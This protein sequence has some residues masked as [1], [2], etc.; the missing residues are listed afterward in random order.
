MYMYIYTEN[1]NFRLFAAK[2]N[3]KRKFSLVGKR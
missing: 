2:G 3:G 1:G